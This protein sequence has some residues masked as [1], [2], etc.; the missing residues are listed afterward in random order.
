MFRPAAVFTRNS[1]DSSEYTRYTRKSN[2]LDIARQAT[3]TIRWTVS[4]K[5]P[6]PAFTNEN[7]GIAFM[8]DPAV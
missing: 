3:D 6:S 2:S 5:R 4:Q 8:S 1:S 7:R